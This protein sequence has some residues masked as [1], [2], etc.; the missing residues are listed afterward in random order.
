[1]KDQRLAGID[2][3]TLTCRLLIAD[4]PAS[5]SLKELHSERRILRLGEGVDQSKR[6]KAEAIDRVI[7]CV[8]DWRKIVEDYAVQRCSAVATSAVRDAANRQEFLDKVKSHTGLDVEILTGEEEARRTML[9]IRSG[10]LPLGAATSLFMLPI[11][12]ISAV[13]ILRGVRKRGREIG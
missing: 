2:I 5:G 11:L 10:D 9:G 12:A 4:V 7:R 13:F 6:L 8:N 1:M 3:G